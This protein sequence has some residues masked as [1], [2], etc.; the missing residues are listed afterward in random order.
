MDLVEKK[1]AIFIWE[2]RTFALSNWFGGN[3]EE[4]LILLAPRIMEQ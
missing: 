2:D 3:I 4:G 1:Y